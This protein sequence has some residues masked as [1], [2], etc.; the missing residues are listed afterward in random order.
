MILSR[1]DGDGLRL[2]QLVAEE[3]DALTAVDG[4]PIKADGIRRRRL[5]P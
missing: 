3:R 1:E 5:R 4:V 2:R